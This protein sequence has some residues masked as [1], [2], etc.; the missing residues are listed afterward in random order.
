MV[1]HVL[2]VPSV[3]L[4]AESGTA[5]DCV[6]GGTAG[7]ERYLPHLRPDV[8]LQLLERLGICTVDTILKV[9]P[10]EE[11]WWREIRGV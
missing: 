7:F 11:V 10:Q 8:I 1:E 9:S 4:Q 3:S 2:H 5:L 6:D